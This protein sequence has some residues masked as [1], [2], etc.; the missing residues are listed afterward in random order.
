LI[1]AR[2]QL[3]PGRQVYFCSMGGFDTHSAQ[4]GTHS[5]LLLQPSQGLGAFHLGTLELGLSGQVTSFTQSEFGRTMQSNGSGSDHGWGS[6]QLVIGGA[7][8]GGIYGQMPTFAFTGP[9][10]ATNRGV[11]IPTISTAQFGATLGRWFGASPQDLA[12]A[13]PTV[14]AFPMSDMGF[15][16]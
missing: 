9:D 11:W 6:H 10:D 15:M 2:S 1:Q 4:S 5:N 12:W 16:V 8:R 7:V 3:G 14:G 13:F